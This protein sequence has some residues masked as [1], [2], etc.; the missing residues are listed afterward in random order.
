MK[1]SNPNQTQSPS[2]TARWRQILA[3]QRAGAGLINQHIEAARLKHGS[4]L[5]RRASSELAC[6][7]GLAQP[8][9][10]THRGELSRILAA[11]LAEARREQRLNADKPPEPEEISYTRRMVLLKITD[12]ILCGT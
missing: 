8:A 6:S 10:A 4:P 1:P 12:R 11:E 2:V 5:I 7:L 9:D 3:Q